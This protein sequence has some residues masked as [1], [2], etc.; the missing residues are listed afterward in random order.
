M[1]DFN[2]AYKLTAKVEGGYANN[3][4]DSGGETWKGV[5]RNSHSNWSGWKIVDSFKSKPNFPSN[6]YS[7]VELN[8]AVLSLY[9]SVYWNSMSLD[10]LSD[11]KVANE[12]YDTGVNMGTGVA[13]VYLQ[14]VL[15][16][17]NNNGRLFP[18]LLIDGQIGKVTVGAF[19]SLKQSDKNIVWKFLNCLQG[20]K[21]IGIAEA[22]RSQEQ[23]I[24]SW[25]SRVFEI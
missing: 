14:R 9:K 18:D 10:L 15:N 21:Y 24:R 12:I 4:S 20:S 3:P 25:A 22:N 17:V 5:A 13:G 8:T 6:L 23:F 2:I 7:S 1:A 19:N 11:Q 16:V